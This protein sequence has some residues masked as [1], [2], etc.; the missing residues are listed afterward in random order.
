MWQTQRNTEFCPPQITSE[1]KKK[2]LW[3]KSCMISLASCFQGHWGLGTS[4]VPVVTGCPQLLSHGSPGR[5]TERNGSTGNSTAGTQ[6]GTQLGHIWGHLLL[7]PWVL[8]AG[9]SSR[10]RSWG[11]TTAGD[12]AGDASC[13]PPACWAQPWAPFL[14]W[15][16]WDSKTWEHCHS[17]PR[18]LSGHH[19]HMSVLCAPSAPFGRENAF[20]LPAGLVRDMRSFVSL[21]LHS[22][23]WPQKGSVKYC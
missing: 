5:T 19:Q 11:K 21:G 9:H 4:P 1:K 22:L 16:N 8:G 12:T 7:L 10:D 13:C 20:Y 15:G 6:L 23:L 2:F 17:C 18:S 14:G 3:V